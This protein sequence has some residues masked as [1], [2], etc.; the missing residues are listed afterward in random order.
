MSFQT[1]SQ[2]GS[3]S[4]VTRNKAE[5][6]KTYSTVWFESC[7][8]PRKIQ[9]IVNLFDLEYFNVHESYKVYTSRD[10]DIVTICIKARKN[11]TH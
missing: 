6:C 9:L 7:A 3:L 1:V 4:K 2:T 10:T 11:S 8:C 5:K